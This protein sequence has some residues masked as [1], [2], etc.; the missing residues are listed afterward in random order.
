MNYPTYIQPS[1]DDDIYEQD[2]CW[3][4]LN[5]YQITIIKKQCLNLVETLML[6]NDMQT[7]FANVYLTVSLKM[8]QV[9]SARCCDGWTWLRVNAKCGIWLILFP[10]KYV[11]QHE[12]LK[13]FSTHV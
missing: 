5:V 7:S 9:K 10:P 11:I 4:L 8:T 3:S 6:R 12:T 1:E 13:P 2:A